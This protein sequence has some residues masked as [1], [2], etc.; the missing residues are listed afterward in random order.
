MKLWFFSW[1]YDTLSLPWWICLLWLFRWFSLKIKL[2]KHSVVYWI[3]KCE[4]FSCILHL[5]MMITWGSILVTHVMLP[6][7]KHITLLVINRRYMNFSWLSLCSILYFWSES[8]WFS[9]IR[10][11]S[12]LLSNFSIRSTW[13]T[14]LYMLRM[15]FL[16]LRYL[17][18]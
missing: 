3:F 8:S 9:K 6:T 18:C 2:C 1:R 5:W 14:L 7:L 16:I 10:R 12:W 15:E 4:N 13:R 11:I 17:W